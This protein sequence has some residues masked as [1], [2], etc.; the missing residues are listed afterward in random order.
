[1]VN[2]KILCRQHLLGEHVE[3][4]MFLGTI[5]KGKSIQGY[6][7]R[8]LVEVHNLAA[9][10]DQ[11]AQEMTE[12]GYNHQSPFPADFYH[13]ELGQV[14]SDK[15]LQDLIGRCMKCKERHD[16]FLKKRP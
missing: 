12:R 7:N 5:A 9:R 2:P 3:S 11:L 10:H 8:G 13:V 4:H 15:S 6:L 16:N 14:D 1:M